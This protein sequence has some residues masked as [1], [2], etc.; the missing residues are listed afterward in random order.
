MGKLKDWLGYFGGRG[1]IAPPLVAPELLARQPALQGEVAA[2]AEAYLEPAVFD[3]MDADKWPVAPLEETTDRPIRVLRESD[4][5][6]AE[7]GRQVRQIIGESEEGFHFAVEV[8]REGDTPASAEWS[9]AFEERDQVEREA[10]EIAGHQI[11]LGQE[12][13]SQ[14]EQLGVV[15]EEPEIA[16]LL[17]RLAHDRA[18]P[19]ID[20]ERDGEAA[21]PG[22][23]DSE[24]ELGH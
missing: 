12:R 15:R 2:A 21:S 13:P 16:E 10:A 8:R 22:Y 19:R 3:R 20:L 1:N 14:A 18:Q 6:T 24:I 23:D 9:P 5:V 7:D 11:Q 17:R 4:W